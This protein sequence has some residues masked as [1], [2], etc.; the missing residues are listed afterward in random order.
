M[1]AMVSS[2]DGNSLESVQRKLAEA[3]SSVTD[4]EARLQAAQN[5][6]FEDRVGC[7]RRRCWSCDTCL[8]GDCRSYVPLGHRIS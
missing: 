2:D 5:R 1:E 7:C 6:Q 3:Q 8:R 4:T